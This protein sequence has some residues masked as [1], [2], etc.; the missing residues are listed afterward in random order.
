M[1]LGKIFIRIAKNEPL[2]PSEW[3]FLDDIGTQ[4]QT[5]SSIVSRNT[6]SNGDLFLKSPSIDSPDFRSSPLRVFHCYNILPTLIAN[7]T[8]TAFTFSTSRGDTSVFDF[9]NNDLS[10]IKIDRS[11]HN[12]RIDG[13]LDWDAD[14]SGYRSLF[15]SVHDSDGTQVGVKEICTVEAVEQAG[16]PTRI[17]FAYTE[18]IRGIFP[19]GVYFTMYVKHETGADL[20]LLQ[21][22]M[23][24]SIA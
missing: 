17:N 10:K 21:F 24:V 2:A 6:G 15:I 19:K 3:R 5:L 13:V 16:I 1:E 7:N 12:I 18:D 14:P 8:L 11:Q 4:L 9:Y 20:N 23:S 22:V